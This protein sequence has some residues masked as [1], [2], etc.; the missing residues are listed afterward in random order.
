MRVVDLF[1]GLG[2][3]SEGFLQ[4]GHDVVRY[5]NDP[6]F[7]AVPNTV[8]RDVFDMTADDFRGAEVVLASPPCQCFSCMALRYSWPHGFPTQRTKEMMVLVRH[9]RRIITDADPPFW[10]TSGA[11]CRT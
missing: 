2:G 4:R 7:E 10:P 3:F 9:T 5:D 6:R 8:I 11:G 1:S